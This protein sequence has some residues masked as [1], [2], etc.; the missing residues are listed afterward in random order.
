M[1]PCNTIQISGEVGEDPKILCLKAPCHLSLPECPYSMQLV[2]MASLGKCA[3]A[4]I[5]IN[6]L[7]PGYI[8]NPSDSLS[9]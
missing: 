3:R 1:C 6:V 5:P 8:E 4:P 9:R 7:P 2:V